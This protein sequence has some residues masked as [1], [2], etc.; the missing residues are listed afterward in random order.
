[1]KT[2]QIPKEKQ[3]IKRKELC[4]KEG[5]MLQWLMRLDVL[6]K[7]PLAGCLA[8]GP[9]APP[10]PA[11]AIATSQAVTGLVQKY[12][13][14][15]CTEPRGWGGQDEIC[16]MSE[17]LCSPQEVQNIVIVYFWVLSQGFR[18]Q[19]RLVWYSSCSSNGFPA[20]RPPAS[21]SC[22]LRQQV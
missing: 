10:Q 3:L 2:W 15:E 9:Q 5:K 21:V 8:S 7:L 1:M 20:P 17:Y 14:R 4:F 19:P 11:A 22:M 13:S 16:F 6:G 18:L 12:Y